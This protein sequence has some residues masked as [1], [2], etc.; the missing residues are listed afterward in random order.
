MR[1][2]KGPHSVPVFPQ[3]PDMSYDISHRHA[4]DSEDSESRHEG[5]AVP[6]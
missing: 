2:R 5:G 4:G 6:P 1:V 3:S